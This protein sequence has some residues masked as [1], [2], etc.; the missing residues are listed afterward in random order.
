MLDYAAN[1]R[2]KL[3]QLYSSSYNSLCLFNFSTLLFVKEQF[4]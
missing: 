1:S 2:I 4:K 3:V